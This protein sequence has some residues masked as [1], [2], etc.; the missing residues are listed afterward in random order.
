MELERRRP[1]GRAPSGSEWDAQQG[2][3][4]SKESRQLLAVAA[5]VVVGDTLSAERATTFCELVAE[6]EQRPPPRYEDFRGRSGSSAWRMAQDEW[7]AWLGP[8]VSRRD[9]ERPNVPGACSV[10]KRAGQEQDWLPLPDDGDERARAWKNALKT[11]ARLCAAADAAGKA[12]EV[13]RKTA[14]RT[15]KRQRQL[16][17]RQAR[18]PPKLVAAVQQ[19]WE[20]KAVLGK[21]AAC[22]ALK[23]G[24]DQELRDADE[25]A[26]G[27]AVQIV[28][29]E[30]RKAGQPSAKQIKAF[31]S[32][33]R[34]DSRLKKP[35][36]STHRTAAY[37]TG[38]YVRAARHLQSASHEDRERLER[39]KD[40][41]EF[42]AAVD[43]EAERQQLPPEQLVAVHELLTGDLSTTRD[44]MAH[45]ETLNIP[46]VAGGSLLDLS[47]A[48]AATASSSLPRGCPDDCKGE[49]CNQ[50]QE[51]AQ[52]QQVCARCRQG[53]ACFM[54]CGALTIHHKSLLRPHLVKY[55]REM[56]QEICK[57]EKSA[58]AVMRDAVHRCRN[59][60]RP[61]RRF[62]SWRCGAAPDVHLTPLCDLCSA[63]VR[64]LQR[65]VHT[66]LEACGSDVLDCE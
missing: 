35:Y 22:E 38:I 21:Q 53:Q 27:E 48:A 57:R 49:H 40:P 24:V 46:H 64:A 25:A 1:P 32:L 63:D 45:L 55:R 18:T 11:Y 33:L 5:E 54:G 43:W 6:A 41:V 58:L 59:R 47:T 17:E 37:R 51:Y 13:E 19:E 61:C 56:A 20:Q 12:R 7:H 42:R 66:A 2:A 30:R 28:R 29:R 52:R 31:T 10:L 44:S 62:G 15:A 9:Q 14:E 50:Q 60:S 8:M 39:L 34:W 36:N 26:V 65:F 16:E 23:R 3:W 4:I